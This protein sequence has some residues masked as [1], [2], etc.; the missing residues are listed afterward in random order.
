MTFYVDRLRQQRLRG[1]CLEG[2]WCHLA[3][4]GALEELHAFAERMA[5]PGRAFHDHPRHPHYDLTASRRAQAIAAGA[6]E[7]SSKELVKRC[8]RR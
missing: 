5:F 2:E 3:T 6:V 7:V 1:T 4:D 8:F